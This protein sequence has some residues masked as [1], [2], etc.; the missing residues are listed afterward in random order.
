M[1]ILLPTH[2]FKY[3]TT[4]V[5]VLCTNTNATISTGINAAKDLSLATST[6]SVYDFINNAMAESNAP[7]G[8]VSS[9]LKLARNQYG[10]TKGHIFL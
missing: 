4:Y 10:L 5:S 6:S 7:A 8:I 9:T 2:V 1:V 3:L